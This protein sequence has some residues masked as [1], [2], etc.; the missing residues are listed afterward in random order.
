MKTIIS[1]AL[2]A[3]MFAGVALAHPINEPHVCD[4]DPT[5]VLDYP[6][7]ANKQGVWYD[8]GEYFFGFE[9][10]RFLE[11]VA[12]KGWSKVEAITTHYRVYK[13]D[14]RVSEIE[15]VHTESKDTVEAAGNGN[16]DSGV[17]GVDYILFEYSED[18]RTVF[19]TYNNVKISGPGWNET[20]AP[21]DA[22]K[23]LMDEALLQGNEA[24]KNRQTWD[25]AAMIDPSSQDDTQE[26]DFR[27]PTELFD[28]LK[29]APGTTTVEP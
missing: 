23:S 14:C 16:S 24:S 6:G 4:I 26:F 10:K 22:A 8:R 12:Y 19:A 25:P 15:I 2:A 1:A 27:N 28:L 5:S 20:A 3:T 29:N 21:D 17:A 7:Y 18:Y 11:P 13:A 9:T